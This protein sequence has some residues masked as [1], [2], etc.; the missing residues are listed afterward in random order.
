MSPPGRFVLVDAVVVDIV[1]R[2]EKVP[3]RGSDVAV[4]E[5]S[6]LA[7]GG[8]NVM[9]AASRLGL[10]AVYG[11]ILGFGPFATIARNAL[12]EEGII[13]A[14][15]PASGLDT[16]FVVALV[17]PD[18]LARLPTETLFIFDPGP[19]VGDIATS[20][21]DAVL[22]RADWF[23]CNEREAKVLTGCDPYAAAQGLLRRLNRGSVIV[24]CG[25]KGCIVAVRGMAT[26]EVP[27]FDVV[28]VDS[29][30]AGDCHVGSFAALLVGGRSPV[31]AARWSNAA[32]AL[33]VSRLGPARGP[34]MGE[35]E[36]FM[37]SYANRS[38]G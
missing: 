8:F 21:L 30:G 20:H 32:A 2:V 7:G 22:K 23:T 34:T 26:Y 28:V 24:R 31:E 14:L 38:G 10:P 25:S 37:S 16:G 5:S 33:S 11:G 9:A 17:E 6:S 29:N 18:L 15:P 3:E 1:L 19:L 13:V 36:L 4:D 35:L 27:G 12:R